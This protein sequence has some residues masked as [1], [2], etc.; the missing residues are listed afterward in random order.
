MYP[1]DR[2]GGWDSYGIG[3]FPQGVV[4]EEGKVGNHKCPAMRANNNNLKGSP[5]QLQIWLINS[6]QQNGI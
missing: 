3:G 6:P 4:I 5:C 1:W 2:S